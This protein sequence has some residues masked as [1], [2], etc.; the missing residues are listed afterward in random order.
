M[1]SCYGL[2]MSFALN[3]R[4]SV[5]KWLHKDCILEIMRGPINS[6]GLIGDCLGKGS[7]TGPKPCLVSGMMFM[8]PMPKCSTEFVSWHCV[9]ANT[10]PAQAR[11]LSGLIILKVQP[12]Q[13]QEPL[14]CGTESG[15]LPAWSA[16]RDVNTG[17]SNLCGHIIQITKWS[18]HCNYFE[19]NEPEHINMNLWNIENSPMLHMIY[20][21]MYILVSLKLKFSSL[22]LLWALLPSIM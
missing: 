5:E 13:K 22:N 6:Q 1:S 9:R 17:F 18:L 21:I 15:A 12:R 10:Q 20:C 4:S 16:R 19:W 11:L 14:D 7:L 2:A 3:L 8:S